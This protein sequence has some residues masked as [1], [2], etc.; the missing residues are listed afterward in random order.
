MYIQLAKF[1]LTDFRAQEFSM[2][3]TRA[4][5]DEGPSQVKGTL[6]MSARPLITLMI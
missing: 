4:Q 6:V 1:I 5:D 3:D 2:T